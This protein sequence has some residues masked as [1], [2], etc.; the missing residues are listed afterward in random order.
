MTLKPSVPK[1]RMSIL[2]SDIDL[3]ILVVRLRLFQLKIL[4]LNILN[5]SEFSENF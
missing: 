1:I 5:F 4:F 2:V 3:I